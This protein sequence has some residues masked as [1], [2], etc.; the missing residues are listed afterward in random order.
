MIG[1]TG[2]FGTGKSTVA[3][4][5]GRRGAVA[6]S[7]DGIARAVLQKSRIRRRLARRFGAEVVTPAGVDKRLLARRGFSSKKNWDDLCRIIHPEVLRRTR[8]KL[9][10]IFRRRPDAVVVLDVPLLIESGMASWVD[11]LVVVKAGRRTQRARLVRKG[12]L[13]AEVRRRLRWQMPLEKKVNMA[14]V[15][16]DNDGSRRSTESQVQRLWKRLKQEK[17]DG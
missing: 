16:I 9:K 3:E 10:A 2:N 14:D 13:P 12:W 17:K 15:V 5:F 6:I 8:E 7:A 1:V 11:P 4:M